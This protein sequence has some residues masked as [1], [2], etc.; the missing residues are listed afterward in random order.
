MSSYQCR[1]YPGSDRLLRCR[2]MTLWAINDQ[3]APQQNWH[4]L[5]SSVRL[6][7]SPDAPQKS[8]FQ[9]TTPS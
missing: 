3:S 2:E 8:M 5:T 4:L 9:L 1:L 7:G 6:C